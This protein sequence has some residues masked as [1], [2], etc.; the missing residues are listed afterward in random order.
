MIGVLFLFLLA[1]S[2]AHYQD[3]DK[4]IRTSHQDKG[5]RTWTSTRPTTNV[6]LLR[7]L[8]GE[9]E[10]EPEPES[11]SEPESE[12]EQVPEA[13]ALPETP[14]L[15]QLGTSTTWTFHT[16]FWT[17]S[18]AIL[19]V[20]SFSCMVFF[21]VK[22]EAEFRSF[23]LNSVQLYL[24]FILAISRTIVFFSDPYNVHQPAAP[25]F[26]IILYG[27][28]FP[29]V[30]GLV[31]T[32]TLAS[33]SLL[34]SIQHM[35]RRKGDLLQQHQTLFIFI[36]M[37]QVVFQMISD[38]VISFAR[39]PTTQTKDLTAAVPPLLI[40]CHLFF[41]IYGLLLGCLLS[42]QIKNL[43]VLQQA[44][45]KAMQKMQKKKTRSSVVATTTTNNSSRMSGSRMLSNLKSK[46]KA[47]PLLQFLRPLV[48]VCVLHFGYVGS[49]L[50]YIA[51]YS[52]G[53]LNQVSVFL[54]FHN[55]QRSL[56]IIAGV[57]HLYFCARTALRKMF[58]KQ[59]IKREKLLKKEVHDEKELVKRSERHSSK[60]SRTHTSNASTASSHDETERGSV[61]STTASTHF[62]TAQNEESDKVVSRTYTSATSGES[63]TEDPMKQEK[64]VDESIRLGCI[65]GYD[66]C[67]DYVD[68][69]TRLPLI[70]THIEICQDIP[71]RQTVRQ[72]VMLVL[73]DKGFALI[74]FDVLSFTSPQMLFYSGKF[75][76]CVNGQTHLNEI[77]NTHGSVANYVNTKV[78]G[79][80]KQSMATVLEDGSTGGGG[81][82]SGGKQENTTSIYVTPVDTVV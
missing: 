47:D 26:P 78:T 39:D 55:F 71:N 4:S 64:F 45:S 62:T 5:P 2:N 25:H 69:C 67:I 73:K 32:M 46:S 19:T 8:T 56:E 77:V 49:S 54:S 22:K 11:E 15:F 1:N 72:R 21:W 59:R 27:L 50:A 24:V 51:V 37:V 16:V 9:P 43:F 61:A 75:A 33:K 20:L 48:V 35:E 58:R 63:G 82:G 70:S 29:A 36:V 44:R 68:V 7:K 81:G 52:S 13:E 53:Q 42:T 18:F 17:I 76:V 34:H 12:P 66:W 40:S 41:D 23:T 79:I 6:V 74:D 65:V 14:P 80:P 38:V 60:N 31:L 57:S 10:S 3:E 28:A 30:N